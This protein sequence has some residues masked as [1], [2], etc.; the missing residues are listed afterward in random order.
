[1]GTI[2]GSWHENCN[3]HICPGNAPADLRSRWRTRFSAIWLGK[4]IVIC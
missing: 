4:E 2:R 3:V 1:M